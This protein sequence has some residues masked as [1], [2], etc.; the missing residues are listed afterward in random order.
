MCTPHCHRHCTHRASPVLSA[1]PA[2]VPTVPVVDYVADLQGA[3]TMVARLVRHAD[4][5]L[6][7]HGA[8]SGAAQAALDSSLHVLSGMAGLLETWCSERAA[9]DPPLQWLA[10]IVL[11]CGGSCGVPWP[12]ATAC[13]PHAVSCP[14]RPAGFLRLY[15]LVP[16]VDGRRHAGG[17]T[18]APLTILHAD[19]L[20][21][22]CQLGPLV[23]PLLQGLP[24]AHQ[25]GVVQLVLG[26]AV[27]ALSNCRRTDDVAAGSTEDVVERAATTLRVLCRQAGGGSV[28]PVCAPPP[29]QR[30]SL[31]CWPA[32][33]P[34]P[35]STPCNACSSAAAAGLPTSAELL[36]GLQQGMLLLQQPARCERY[37]DAQGQLV[38]GLVHALHGVPPGDAQLRAQAE[39]AID[40]LVFQPLAAALREA[41]ALAGAGAAPPRPAQAR[42]AVWRL[43]AA[44]RQYQALLNSLESYAWFDED[45]GSVSG[46]GNCMSN[47]SGAGAAAQHAQMARGVA[48]AVASLLACWPQLAEMCGWLGRLPVGPGGGGLAG[49]RR[50]LYQELSHCVCSCISLDRDASQQVLPSLVDTVATCLFLPGGWVGGSWGRE[51][52]EQQ[53]VLVPLLLPAHPQLSRHVQLAPTGATVLSRPLIQALETYGG[54]EEYQ[55]S[56]LG[57]VAA[58]LSEPPAR[59]LAALRGGDAD[60]EAAQALLSLLGCCLRQA[61]RWRKV[62]PPAAGAMEAVLALGLPLAAANTA[63]HHRD[64]SVQAVSTLAALLA[65][66]LAA[67]SPLHGALLGFAA[68]HGSVLVRGL[69]LALLALSSGSTLPK[70]S[71]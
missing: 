61:T 5:A 8:G 50:E 67:D 39:Q 64:T 3:D 42:A 33:P 63:C 10:G 4:A 23:M 44:L 65:L 6:A 46:N 35:H 55:Q 41:E 58:I 2:C 32:Q 9:G 1:L 51:G 17:A 7:Q 38:A 27:R 18:A 37:Q 66:V 47:G 53:G 48:A 49:M 26:E 19:L 45:G 43:H 62:A 30:W 70:V 21:S 15:A 60:P 12:G 34:P 25:R 24:T 36:A 40:A 59:Q 69:L 13:Q 22:F 20:A 52:V 56:L 71:L 14:A 29:L 11:A 54:A 28:Q 16:E 68:Q 31:A 57:T